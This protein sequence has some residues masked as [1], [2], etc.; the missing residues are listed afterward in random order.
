MV[1]PQI[2]LVIYKYSG[3]CYSISKSKGPIEDAS[4]RPNM[5]R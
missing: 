3:N 2:F 4:V 1:K 5:H